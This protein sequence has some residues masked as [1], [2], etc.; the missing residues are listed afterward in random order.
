MSIFA[1]KRGLSQPSKGREA[2]PATTRV[3]AGCA[4][5]AQCSGHGY[6]SLTEEDTGLREVQG[7]HQGYMWDGAGFCSFGRPA[8]GPLGAE[9]LGEL[10]H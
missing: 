5:T 8:S 3:P 10:I 6:P 7:P 1:E 4:A 9:A 2:G